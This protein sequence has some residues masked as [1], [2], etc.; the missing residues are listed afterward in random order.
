MNIC[1]SIYMYVNVS[2]YELIYLLKYVCIIYIYVCCVIYFPKIVKKKK[3]YIY[4]LQI[5]ISL[6]VCYIYGTVKYVLV[7][8][9]KISIHR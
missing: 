4:K 7:I 3:I 1:N 6:Q 8:Q 5:S 9:D 2:I